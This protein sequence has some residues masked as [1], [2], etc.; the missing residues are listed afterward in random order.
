ML[1]REYVAEVESKQ[2]FLHQSENN[3][4]GAMESTQGLACN[5]RIDISELIKFTDGLTKQQ[6]IKLLI[7]P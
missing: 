5:P 6:L 3:V 7:Q 2:R 4:I 1:S